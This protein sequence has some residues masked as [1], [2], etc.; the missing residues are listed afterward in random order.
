M[1]GP[2]PKGLQEGGSVPAGRGA[3][4]MSK[5]QT[6]IPLPRMHKYRGGRAGYFKE[7]VR[8]MRHVTWPT[9]SE[10][11]RL[12]GTV[13]GVCVMVTLLLFGLSVVFEM[14][15]KLFGIGV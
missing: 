6:Q 13:L 3:Q 5:P 4:I 12:T 11:T 15:L 1:I 9:P 10:A 14:I 2:V 8:E 7:V